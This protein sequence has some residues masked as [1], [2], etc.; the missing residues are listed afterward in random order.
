MKIN[1]NKSNL[2]RVNLNEDETKIV[3]SRVTEI[4]IKVISK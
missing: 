1:Y 2:V 4:I 3:T